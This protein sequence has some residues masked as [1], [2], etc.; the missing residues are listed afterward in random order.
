MSWKRM[1]YLLH[2]FLLYLLYAYIVYFL[3]QINYLGT[4]YL[5]N[6]YP[7]IYIS[8]MHLDF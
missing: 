7:Q 5:E 8:L 4:T 3:Q 1:F 2:V 6:I